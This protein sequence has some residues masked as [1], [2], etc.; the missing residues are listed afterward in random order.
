MVGDPFYVG[1]LYKM[2]EI[3]LGL[4]EAPKIYQVLKLQ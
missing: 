4:E 3:L 1:P 2:N